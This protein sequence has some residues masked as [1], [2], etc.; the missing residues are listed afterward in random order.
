MP[1]LDA[2]RARL[3]LC[4]YTCHEFVEGDAFDTCAY[5]GL[6]EWIH[7]YKRDVTALLA[8]LDAC[9]EFVVNES[10]A[11]HEWILVRKCVGHRLPKP[12]MWKVERRGFVL[13]KDGEW[14]YEPNPSS[15]D[16][17]FYARCRFDT[18][19]E[20]WK[21]A[22]DALDAKAQKEDGER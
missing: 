1:D 12:V 21:A 22:L 11:P 9:H 17:E 4:C 7:H 15:R 8:A 2:I 6:S 18:F 16:D 19:E 20:A 10:D 14:E 5:C 3:G 13:A